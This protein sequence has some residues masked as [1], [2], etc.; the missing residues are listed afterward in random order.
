MPPKAKAKG[1]A[2]KAKAK[3][4]AASARAL[5]SLGNSE[6]EPWL[7]PQSEERRHLKQ[8][9]PARGDGAAKG[10]LGRPA[11]GRVRRQRARADSEPSASRVVP[12]KA[13]SLNE[14]QTN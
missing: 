1:A 7:Q 8:S 12:L 4:A 10:Q 11:G 2:A 14:G 9:E 5:S 3:A 6:S 13:E